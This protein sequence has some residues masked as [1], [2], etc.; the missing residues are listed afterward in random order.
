MIPGTI[1]KNLK[2]ASVTALKSLA[3]LISL[4]LFLVLIAV[5][6]EGGSKWTMKRL[7]GVASDNSP[8]RF[9]LEDMQGTLLDELTFTNFS[10]IA[11]EPTGISATI[12]N[13][14]LAWD[15]LALFDKS[16]RVRN[17]QIRQ[18]VI[19]QG[20]TTAIE[21]DEELALDELLQTLFDI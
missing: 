16:L 21:P 14:V 1:L 8:Y 4:V 6:T 12:G 13:L 15:P 3:F 9:S 17:L 19:D 10:V 20:Q 18:L 5:G 11:D 7:L 2:S